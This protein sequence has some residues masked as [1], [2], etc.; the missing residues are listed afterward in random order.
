MLVKNDFRLLCLDLSIETA[1]VKLPPSS[2]YTT[3]LGKRRR[4]PHKQPDV[5]IVVPYLP[6]GATEEL[7][8]EILQPTVPAV[9]LYSACAKLPNHQQSGWKTTGRLTFFH[10]MTTFVWTCLIIAV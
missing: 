2:Q 8:L 4:H 1:V 10:N 7:D 6:D 3:I 5:L 9:E